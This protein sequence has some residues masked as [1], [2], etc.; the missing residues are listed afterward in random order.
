MTEI[1]NSLNFAQTCHNFLITVTK[2]LMLSLVNTVVN[3]VVINNM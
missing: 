2:S 1:N 3:T